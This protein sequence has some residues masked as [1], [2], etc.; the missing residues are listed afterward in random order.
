VTSFADDVVSRIIGRSSTTVA[1]G[2]GPLGIAYGA[3]AVWVANS[4]AGTVSRIDPRTGSV[5][6]IVRVGHRPV[7]VAVSAG[8]V[9]VTIQAR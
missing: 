7:G 3:H 2:A 1:V 8:A 4:R 9:W 6:A 5:A